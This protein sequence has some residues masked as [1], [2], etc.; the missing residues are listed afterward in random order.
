MIVITAVLLTACGGG[1]QTAT[2]AP[3]ETE[4]PAVTE[5]PA[6]TEAPRASIDDG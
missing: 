1:Q 2:Q 5:A 6:A 3:A 4:A